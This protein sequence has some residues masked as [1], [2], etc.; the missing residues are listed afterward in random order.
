MKHEKQWLPNG[1]RL[2]ADGFSDDIIPQIFVV[3]GVSLKEKN[4]KWVGFVDKRP[5][6]TNWATIKMNK[7]LFFVAFFVVVV[8]ALFG[9]QSLHFHFPDLPF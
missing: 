2:K 7:K 1:W 8:D 9:L 4:S 6:K 5:V 3:V